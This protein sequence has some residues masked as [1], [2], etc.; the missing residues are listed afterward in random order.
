M[1]IPFK[2]CTLKNSLLPLLTL[3]LHP[4]RPIS[5]WSIL[6]HTNSPS[7]G[8]LPVALLTTL[9]Q[10]RTVLAFIIVGFVFL[11]LKNFLA[12]KWMM[13][14]NMPWSAE[15]QQVPV[16]PAIRHTLGLGYELLKLGKTQTVTVFWDRTESRLKSMPSLLV[17]QTLL[18]W[19]CCKGLILLR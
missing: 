12:L 8:I 1:I 19:P 5:H 17:V 3:Y 15:H 10:R 14:P 6:T 11:Q 18:S 2:F 9:A 16:M 7:V 4:K 13:E